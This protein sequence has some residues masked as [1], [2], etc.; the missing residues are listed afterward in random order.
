[1]D[2]G[3]IGIG[4]IV[5]AFYLIFLVIALGVAVALYVFHGLGLMGMAKT[6]NLRHPWM[7]FV[8]Y[9]NV[10]LMGELAECAAQPGK[11]RIP[12]RHLALGGQLLYTALMIVWEVMYGFKVFSL[13]ARAGEV[14]DYDMLKLLGR[15]FAFL[16]VVMLV[17]MAFSVLLYIIYW[18]IFNLFDAKHALLYL[19]LSIFVSAAPVIFFLLRKRQPAVQWLDS[20]AAPWS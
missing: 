7:G 4:I 18:K 3:G 19:L 17:G 6:C 11:K 9:A 15:S 16:A 12:W 2:M 10:Y 14:S 20:N 8:P 5:L 13:A 1:M